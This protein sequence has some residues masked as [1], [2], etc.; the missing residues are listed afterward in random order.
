M[1]SAQEPNEPLRL[2]WF[3]YC[4]HLFG[5]WIQNVECSSDELMMAIAAP[6]GLMLRRA[7]ARRISTLKKPIYLPPIIGIFALLLPRGKL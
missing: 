3:F 6:N 4:P 2:E 5:L 1:P 7:D